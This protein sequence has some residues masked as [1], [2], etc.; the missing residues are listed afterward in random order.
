ME[1]YSKF[2]LPPG[3]GVTQNLP[4]TS[5]GIVSKRDNLGP[6]AK[7]LLDSTDV[8]F[9]CKGILIW[10]GEQSIDLT[11]ITDPESMSPTL[12]V[13]PKA[14]STGPTQ[15]LASW[16]ERARNLNKPVTS[17][18]PS[19]AQL[20]L[21]I[22]TKTI[23]PDT[24]YKPSTK[25]GGD[26]LT[27]I[28]LKDQK[29]EAD[30]ALV[31]LQD[32]LHE[33]FEA[34]DQ[35]E[36]GSD[37]PNAIFS[38]AESLEVSGFILSSN[39]HGHIQ[40]AIR[41]VVGF[42][43]VQD[44]PSDYM[45]RIQKLCEKPIVAA[46]SP[47][48]KLDD[49]SNE[50]EA[51]DWLK[52]LD[53]MQNALLA[54]A[55]LLL[56]MSGRQSERDL[57]PEDLVEAIPT[58]L[59]QVFDNCIISAAESRSGGKDANYFEFFSAQKGVIGGLIHQSRKVLSLFADFLA[60]V[61]V[62]EGTI[63]ATEF[64]AAKLIFVENAHTDKDSAIGF[65]RYESVRR[66]AMDVLA[67]IFSKY[68]DQRPFILDEIL[69]SLEKLPS[70]RQS[71]RQ[72][73]L[74]DGKSIQLLTALVMQLV[75]TTALD[76]P[77]SRSARMKR[78]L[79]ASAGDDND[80]SME[81]AKP[82]AREGEDEDEEEAP[83]ERLATKVNRL[84]DNAVRSAQY[85]VKF[86]VQRAMTSTKTGD[87]PFRNI[88]DL[89]TEDLLCVIGST[90]WPAAELLL[91]IMASQMV[92]IADL[93]KSPA[94][95]K[96]M[97]LELLGWMGSGISDLIVTAQHLLPTMEESDGD[98]TDSLRQLFDEYSARSLHLQDLIVPEGPY[99]MTLEYFLQD[100]NTDASAQG[101]YLTHWA[102]T[103]CS[104][105]Y[106]PE[107]KEKIAYDDVTDNLVGLFNK[108]FSD[109]L[110]LETHRCVLSE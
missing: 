27:S 87:Q 109:P 50:S 12:K 61:D 47:N 1:S 20:S 107:D 90:N 56:T 63:T 40:K 46:Q 15:K 70:T 101:F 98:L 105:Y 34:E 21:V 28:R 59:N 10:V 29:E 31:K 97:A 32:L 91:R 82:E 71:A 72:F 78:R 16:N 52:K 89:F 80:E 95:A 25:S 33:I 88:L 57:C 26:K 100:K 39:V 8:A 96:S 36:P 74:A 106:N 68:P 45:N 94:I 38:V 79:S 13:T 19:S 6:F 14:E 58:V 49:P 66:G 24:P 99:R 62:T 86:I 93:D 65:Q 22:P 2:K 44:I 35:L 108:L 75:Q 5:D 55:T 41:K 23:P 11:M 92:G 60:L 83:L 9:R 77:L 102:K 18:L 30:A 53:D 48:F 76:T 104:V 67:K 42:N 110:W 7:M 84:Y 37:G 51:Q 64:L 103:A 4:S 69:V 54:I 17:S 3:A 85:I 43:R 81:E 73:K